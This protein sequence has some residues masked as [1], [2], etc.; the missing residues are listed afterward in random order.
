MEDQNREIKAGDEGSGG[1]G[2][3]ADFDKILILL[4]LKAISWA[5][6][7]LR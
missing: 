6:G 4:V 3:V 7:T 1:G 5:N 2:E